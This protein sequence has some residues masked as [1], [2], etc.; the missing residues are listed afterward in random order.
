MINCNRVTYRKL[1]LRE[2]N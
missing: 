1:F 2:N